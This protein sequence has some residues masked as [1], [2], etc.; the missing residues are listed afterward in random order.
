MMF[1][2]WQRRPDPNGLT[3]PRRFQRTLAG[4]GKL[5]TVIAVRA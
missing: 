1:L 4:A 3:H 5:G 2:P